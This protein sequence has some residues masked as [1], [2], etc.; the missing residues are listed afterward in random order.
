MWM[1]SPPAA[2][3]SV[4]SRCRTASVRAQHFGVQAQVRRAETGS[5]R[6]TC[7]AAPRPGR[8]DARTA[9][10]FLARRF[11]A[12]RRSG[13]GGRPH[14]AGRRCAP[15]AQCRGRAA[16]LQPLRQ[17]RHRAAAGR[18]DQPQTR[19]LCPATPRTRSWPCPGVTSPKRPI[20]STKPISSTSVRCPPVRP[21]RAPEPAPRRLRGER[22]EESARGRA[23]RKPAA[24]TRKRS[25]RRRRRSARVSLHP[26]EV[27]VVAERVGVDV[28]AQLVGNLRISPDIQAWK[29][30]QPVAWLGV[31][32][33][34]RH[35]RHRAGADGAADDGEVDSASARAASMPST[36]VRLGGMGKRFAA[37][38]GDR[39]PWMSMITC[40]FPVSV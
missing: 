23:E 6:R 9:A 12:D 14:R 11:S 38:G 31:V 7:G 32:V 26:F 10:G 8:R 19:V 16:V 27:I 17:Q 28:S 15:P 1:K 34:A 13:R 25:G 37:S 30:A 21:G 40:R 33:D 39:C 3:P 24:C 20:C 35:P 36:S 5:C 2:R 4:V 22:D 18:A 29:P